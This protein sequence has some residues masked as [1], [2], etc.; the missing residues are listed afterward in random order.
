MNMSDFLAEAQRHASAGDR[1][2]DWPAW[3]GQR[4]IRTGLGRG[5]E[6]GAMNRDLE[7]AQSVQKRLLPK[8]RLRSSGLLCET[9]YRPLHGIGGDYYDFVPLD[10]N[11]LGIAIGD[12]SGKGVGA[13]LTMA[14]LQASLRARLLHPGMKPQPLVHSLNRLLYQSSLDYVFASLFYG[15]YDPESRVLRYVNAGHHSPLVVRQEDSRVSILPLR[16]DGMPIGVIPDAVY[17][18]MSFV[19]QPDDLLVGYTDGLTEAENIS[20]EQWGL[21]RLEAILAECAGEYPALVVEAVLKRQE[22]FTHPVAA[23]D[24]ITLMV[25]AV[26]RQPGMGCIHGRCSK[27]RRSAIS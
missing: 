17:E 25:A 2:N 23:E 10:R 11:R 13:A 20:N 3:G 1:R 14:S 7:I 9:Y 15:E 22:D 19:L 8:R 4:A 12:V 26:E 24:D 27:D 21:E 18:E 5:C 16:S 6:E